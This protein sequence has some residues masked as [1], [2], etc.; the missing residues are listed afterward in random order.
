MDNKNIHKGHRQR[1]KELFLKEGLDNFN[2]HQALE[3]LL[4]YALPQRDTN[5]L[6]HSLIDEFGSISGVFDAPLSRLR[7]FGLSENT[8]TLIKLIPE[9]SRIYNMDRADD[10]SK[11][12]D[13]SKLCEYFRPKFIGRTTE[14]MYLLLMDKK[15]K[16]LYCGIIS[17][18]SINTTDVPILKILENAVTYNASYVVLAHNHPL[19]VALPSKDD[20][21]TTRVVSAALKLL[22]RKLLDHIIVS[23]DDEISFSQSIYGDGIFYGKTD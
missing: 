12:V 8:I 23:D 11:H 9:L 17:K 14:V 2:H 3:L 5:P 4:F 13:T 16:E 6:A 19:G 7:T 21:Q 18:G 20:I 22:G 1:I 10:K 15:C